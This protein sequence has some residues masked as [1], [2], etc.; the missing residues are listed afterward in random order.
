[1]TEP[2]DEIAG[3]D[4]AVEDD[5]QD[6]RMLRH[7]DA[8]FY[9]SA[10]PDLA[11][12]DDRA[13]LA[14]FRAIGWL[15]GR[16]PS[17]SFETNGYLMA[18]PDVGRLGINPLLHYVTVG[19]AEGRNFSPGIPIATLNEM[20]FG[21][22]SMDW[23]AMAAPVV[24]ARHYSAG[25]GFRPPPRF[26]AAAH[27]C[28]RGWLEG[29]LPRP[30]YVAPCG[31]AP[32]GVLGR[33]P[34]PIAAIAMAQRAKAA[35][36]AQ[37]AAG[38]QGISRRR[39]SGS[40]NEPQRPAPAAPLPAAA[41][42]DPAA[43][44]QP[45]DESL[46][47]ERRLMMLEWQS[48]MASFLAAPPELPRVRVPDPL[49]EDPSMA[50]MAAHFDADF[51]LAANGDVAASGIDPLRH[52]AET[53]WTEGRDPAPWFSTGYY[54]QTNEDVAGQ[55]INP[56]LHFLLHGR[57]EGRLPKRLG[58]A[59]RRLLD[60]LLPPERKTDHYVT[61]EHDRLDPAALR[62]RLA[63]VILAARGVVLSVSHDCYPLVT[64][65]TQIF[66]ADEQQRF[67]ERGY[68]YI[69]LSPLRGG[70]TLRGAPAEETLTRLVL[71][72]EVAGVATDAEIAATLADLRADMPAERLVAIHCALGHSIEGLLGACLALQPGRAFYWVH[73]YSSICTGFNLLRNE[74]AFCGAPPPDSVACSVCIFGES[75][76]PH[77]ARMRR[78]FD[79]LSFTV[80]APSDAAREVW[81]RG[82]DLPAAAVVT[83]EHCRLS[84][85]SAARDPRPAEAIGTA[86]HPVRVGYIGWPGVHKGWDVFVQAVEAV[87][88]NPGYDFYHFGTP[89]AFT[90]HPPLQR[91]PAVVSPQDRSAMVGLLA[92]HAID[93]VVIASPWPETF[94][95][96][97]YEALA[98]GCDVIT[99]ADSGN[100]ATTIQRTDRGQVLP[101]G[102]A[103]VDF[104]R[105]GKAIAY[106]R[107]RA[108]YMQPR[109]TLS[110]AG[111]TAALVFRPQAVE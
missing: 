17:A 66:I 25:L 59:R 7:F 106:A 55:G 21:R 65:G 100:V 51:Y 12:L 22:S 108:R 50:A 6:D 37:V 99:V 72:G 92:Q 30:G 16:N 20:A 34:P 29:R 24:D 49:P 102:D 15:E 63:A 41:G 54:L 38:A 103:L 87:G 84:A 52:F 68:A 95:Y 79:A 53:G 107:L 71:D 104:F 80:V 85:A 67:N 64:G 61:P 60:T 88:A 42:P 90:S 9:R 97:A 32:A 23:V 77:L 109:G 89:S 93:L 43:P 35:A 94:S 48:A 31:E 81:L 86:A 101:D 78:L 13:A 40:A 91:V 47:L 57:R 19:F 28:F 111:T 70:L 56:F 46:R 2:L 3:L 1:M 96:V 18:N 39:R 69:H 98:A 33:L 10:Y 73:D 27:Y 76:P 62:R 105:S 14:H 74:V 45:A 58:D 110:H 8:Y 36:I 83:V 75:R 44:P 82:S 11:H 26:S 5:G 4:R